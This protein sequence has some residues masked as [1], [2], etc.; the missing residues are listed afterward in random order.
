MKHALLLSLIDNHQ[1]V[2]KRAD[3]VLVPTDV[4]LED[5]LQQCEDFYY[6]ATQVLEDEP[7]DNE[8]NNA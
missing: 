5:F 6:L 2:I 1:K 4:D 8:F 3:S 7:S